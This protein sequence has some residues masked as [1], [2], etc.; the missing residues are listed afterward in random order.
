MEIAT[1]LMNAAKKALQFEGNS[2]F[3]KKIGDTEF[4]LAEK[5]D[6]TIFGFGAIKENGVEYKIG[7]AKK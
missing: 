6:K 1:S 3:P 7:V 5:D 4:F 2:S